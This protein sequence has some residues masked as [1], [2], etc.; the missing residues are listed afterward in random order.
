M[1]FKVNYGAFEP[2][3]IIP[4]HMTLRPYIAVRLHSNGNFY[5]TFGLVDSGADLPLFNDQWAGVLG[6][7]LTPGAQVSIG[8]IGTAGAIAWFF[9]IHL[10]VKSRRFPAR[11]GFSP[12]SPREFGLLGRAGFF[13]AFRLGFDN[14]G[15]RLLYNTYGPAPAAA[16]TPVAPPALPAVHPVAPLAGSP[17]APP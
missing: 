1:T 5:D 4:P 15:A 16:A 7:V 17:T 12:S 2:Y 10:T 8:G 9:D 11:V 3:S 14:P 6:L 13:D